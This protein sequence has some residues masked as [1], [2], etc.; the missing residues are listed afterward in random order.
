M[1][2]T[3]KTPS[4]K[5]KKQMLI[6]FDIDETLIQ[7]IGPKYFHL[8]E[9]SRDKL[10]PDSYKVIEKKDGK[11]SCIIFRPYL[12]E[13]IDLIKKDSFYVPAIWTYSE[14]DYAFD[15]A[16]AI[17]DKFGLS[18]HG[19]AEDYESYDGNNNF[20]HFLYGVDDMVQE[21]EEDYPKN[22]HR[23][24]ERYPKFNVFNTILVDDRHGNMSHNK[25]DENGLYIQGFAPFGATKDREPLNEPRLN[26]DTFK[27]LLDVLK[28]VKKD[29]NDCS[30]QEYMDSLKD[31]NEAVFSERRIE[32][33]GLKKYYK[34]FATKF[35]KR[36]FLGKIP[37][38]SKNFISISNYNEI[39]SRKHG[40][41][42]NKRK[43]RKSKRKSS[44]KT[45]KKRS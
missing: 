35:T 14:R 43:N 39:I 30:N 24:Y 3:N 19:D 2:T 4:E 42:T 33:M 7:F 27:E 17:C 34:T 44:R 12:K 21:D 9:Q 38:D 40:G 18:F 20:F 36:I 1:S 41:K 16:K 32:R 23:I 5:V 13:V 8:F 37:F 10:D 11:N 22:L 6:V 15:I 25:N 31:P 28:A 26:D 45:I 29:I